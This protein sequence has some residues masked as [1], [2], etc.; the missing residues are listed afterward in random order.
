MKKFIREISNNILS[1]NRYSKRTIVIVTDIALCVLCTWFAFIL[2]LEEFILIKDLNFYPALISIIFVIPIFWLFGLYRTI[3]RYTGLSIIFTISASIFAYS[4]LYFLVISVYS[5]QNVPR[6]IGIIQPILLFVTVITSRLSAKFF[7]I[8]IFSIKTKYNKKKNVLI[9]GAGNSG[10][11]LLIALENSPEFNV[12]GFLDDDIELH[13]QLLLGKKIFS[14][15]NLEKLISNS[16]ITLVF[17]ALPSVSRS[18]RNQIIKNLNKFK[19]I[20][21]TLPSILE[22]VD[23]RIKVSDI[24]DLN[25]DDLLNREQVEPNKNLLNKN[26]HLKTVLVTGAGGSIGSELCRQIVKLKPKN[27]LILE[28]N[29]FALYK[30]Y[31]ELLAFNSN[32]K[33]TPL[34]INIQDQSKLELIFDTF[35]VDKVYHAAA[36]KQVPLVE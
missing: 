24:K 5:I 3:F 25:V 32:L 30:I 1:L 22:I 11:Q 10:R 16:N 17:L 8:N 35:K 19:L 4:I 7:L 34:L 21:K 27:L 9:Y 14:L 2:R 18:K 31:E 33:I 15:D 23:G 12:V 26:I 36:Y 6:S 29:E 13:R 20:V 28:I